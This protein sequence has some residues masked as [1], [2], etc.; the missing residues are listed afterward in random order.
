MRKMFVI[1]LTASLLILTFTQLAVAQGNWKENR[2]TNQTSE[3]LHVVFSTW[4]A[5]SGTVTETGYRTVGYYNIPP[6]DFEK[7]YGYQNNPIYLQIQTHTGDPIKPE[8]NTATVRSWL[9]NSDKRDGFAFNIVT[10][11]FG[12]ATP[13]PIS[14]TSV[15]KAQLSNRDGFIK[16]PNNSQIRV[17][18][19]WV[20]VAESPPNPTV[21]IP[22]T[23]LRSAIE[24]ELKRPAN[25]P[26]T[27]ADMETLT[28]VWS[29]YDPF[30][31]GTISDLTG[32]EFATNLKTLDLSGN[33]I[34]DISALANL[35][36]LTSLDLSGNNI[37]DISPL[38]NLVK[39]ETLYLGDNFFVIGGN[40]IS[41]IS[42]LAKLV[43]LTAL[44]LVEN[45]IS[46]ISALSGLTNLKYLYLSGNRISDFSP[47]EALIPNLEEYWNG[48]QEPEASNSL[49]EQVIETHRQTLIR[50]EVKAGLPILLDQLKTPEKQLLL[51]AATIN[52]VINT[53][54]SLDTLIDR[55]TLTNE[56]GRR[57]DQLLTLLQARDE[58]VIAF[59]RDP[60]VLEL[61]KEPAAVDEL[62]AW[63]ATRVTTQKPVVDST[64]GVNIPDPNLRAGIETALRKNT[65]DTITEAD[66]LTLTT[67]EIP[68]R[69]I[70]DLTGL[71]AAENLTKL[72]LYGN[73]IS[74]ISELS[75]MNLISSLHLSGNDIS[76]IS[77]LSGLTNLEYLRLGD[78]DISDIWPLS[79]LTNLTA[80][81][82]RD[83]NISDI[84]ALSQ[85]TNLTDLTLQN[86]NISDIPILSR[87]TNLTALPLS[88]NDISDISALSQLTNL[89][90]L[91]LDD[92][93]IS[94]ISAL[95]GLTNLQRLALDANNI[96]DISAL[97]QLTNL[98]HLFLRDNGISDIS[99]LSQLTNLTWLHL[100]GNQISDFSPIAGLTENLEKYSNENQK[101]VDPNAPVNIPDPNLRRVIADTLNTPQNTPIA[102]SDMAALTTLEAVE[103]S[104]T[105]LTGLA[106]AINLEKLNLSGN[107]ISDVSPIVN[108]GIFRL[109]LSGNNISDISPLENLDSLSVLDLSGNNISDV[110]PI[111]SW[112]L[113]NWRNLGWLDLSD[114]T[115]SDISPLENLDNLDAFLDVLDLSDNN[116]SNVSPLAKLGNLG[117]LRL[118]GNP[119]TDVTPLI[120]LR[121]SGIV[122][123]GV[124]FDD[125]VDGTSADTPV[126]IPDSVLRRTIRRTLNKP[127]NSPLTQADMENLR[128]LDLS[129]SVIGSKYAI[130]DL[131]GLEFATNLEKLNMGQRFVTDISPLANLQNL[132][133]LSLFSEGFSVSDISPLANLRNLEWLSIS[134]YTLSD[135]SPLEKL[136]N[137]RSLN[138]SNHFSKNSISD[139]SLLANLTKLEELDLQKNN[140]S[141]ISPLQNSRNLTTLNLSRNN[142]SD[143]SPLQNSRNLTT[144]NLS[145]NNISDISPLQNSRNLTTLNLSRNNISDISPLQNL[146]KLEQLYLSGNS[147]SDISPL[148][149]SRNLSSLNL[150]SNGLSDVSPLTNLRNLETLNLDGNPITNTVPLVGLIKNGTVISGVGVSYGDTVEI[151]D[152]NLRRAIA[153]SLELPKNT[154]IRQ[155]DMDRLTGLEAPKQ[156]ITNLTGLAFAIN[157][158]YLRLSNNSISDISP[159]ENLVK[160]GNLYLGS[161]SI[162]NISPLQNLTNLSILYLGSN[163]ISNISPLQNLT[164]LK[165]L[166]LAN[167]NI[168]DVSPLEKLI[169]LE[170]LWLDGNPITDTVPLVSLIKNGT[171]IDVRVA[172]GDM[173]EIPDPN[174]HRAIAKTLGL[175]ENTPITQGDM[176]TLT[177]LEVR[178]HSITDLTG[179]AFATNLQ[180][181]NLSNNSISDISP[182]QNLINLEQLLLSK[183]GIS[184]ISPLQ[185][186]INLNSLGLAN[187]SISDISPLQNL[188][189][190]NSLGL[191]N[192]NIPDISP[193]EKLIKLERL[194]FQENSISDISPLKNLIK[195]EWLGL[196]G[197]PITDTALLVSFIKHGT[198]LD[199]QVS[200]GDTIEILDPN[201]RRAIE[202]AL[203]LPENTTI[204]QSDMDRLTGLE[205]PKQS[206]TNLTGLEFAINLSG[207]DLQENSIS[208]ISP[209]EN[210]RL[211]RKLDLRNNNISDISP[212]QNFPSLQTLSLGGNS[213]SDISPLQ[214]LLN[215][216][217]LDLSHNSISDIS[218]LQ[219]LVELEWLLDLSHNNISDISPIPQARV[220]ALDLS[221]NNISDISPILK[222]PV[223]R[224]DASYDME[225]LDL[226]DNPI[227][228]LTHLIEFVKLVKSA[229]NR[230]RW[231]IRNLKNLDRKQFYE[232]LDYTY[233]IS[234]YTFG[235]P[236][237]FSSIS[238]FRDYGITFRGDNCA[239]DMPDVSEKLAPEIV[240]PEFEEFRIKSNAGGFGYA[241]PKAAVFT[242][243]YAPNDNMAW[244]IADTV[245]DDSEER[246]QGRVIITVELLKG[247]NGEAF[248]LRSNVVHATTAWEKA[249]NLKFDIIDEDDGKPKPSDIRVQVTK[250]GPSGSYGGAEYSCSSGINP[251]CRSGV[252]IGAPRVDSKATLERHWNANNA[253]MKLRADSGYRTALHEF[254]HALGLT[255][256]HLN[257][258]F[259]EY[260]KWKFTK[261]ELYSKIRKEFG[262]S[263]SEL[264]NERIDL[265]FLE[266]MD[267][268]ETL[269][270][271]DMESVMTYGLSGNLIELRDG[272][273]SHVK[274][275][276]KKYN[277]IPEN[278]QLSAGDQEFIRRCYGDPRQRAIISGSIEIEGEECDNICLSKD[279]IDTSY[280]IKPYAVFTTD[281]Y[282]AQRIKTFTW[283]GDCRVEVHIGTRK[284]TEDEVEIAVY[285]PFYQEDGK[286]KTTGDLDSIQCGTATLPYGRALEIDVRVVNEN[287]VVNLVAG[288]D[289]CNVPGL[290]LYQTTLQ[291]DFLAA[292]GDWAELTIKLQAKYLKPGASIP[293]APS[294]LI[295]S[296]PIVLKL[297]TS[298]APFSDINGD[299]QVDLKDLLLISKHIGQTAPAHLN[300]DV[301]ADG[302]VT[303]ADLVQVAQFLGQS[304]DGASA[305]TRF[306][307]PPEVTYA[308]VEGWI[309]Q[310][311]LADDGSSVF[312]QGIANLEYLLILMIPE[313]TALLTNYPN[314]FNPETWIPY[315]LATHA[316][317]TL[318]IYAA[319]GTVVR[320]LDLG[321]QEAGYYQ[322]KSRAAYWDGRN[323]VGERVASGLYFY[324]LTAGDFAATR[325]M[326]IMK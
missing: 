187:N 144:L 322:S 256:E 207:L 143:I 113:A 30:D 100:D 91:F 93:D 296:R 88:G 57:L 271:F 317:V 298:R 242:P 99:A 228:D 201:L 284:V 237:R 186:L 290:K 51:T 178:E 149:N 76:D 33:N 203:K 286:A 132:K 119:I 216:E 265:N 21:N 188:I 249:G 252:G 274:A 194:A 251:F 110:S 240:E 58:G 9:P 235:Y 32:L 24:R 318:T 139:I 147:I 11:V 102:E 137:L 295:D 281:V 299:G 154:T 183:N 304:Q 310:A 94:D 181:L 208:D 46:N 215:L 277:G 40:N 269:S 12:T 120:G 74:D 204:R 135:I 224:E 263:K 247:P 127:I 297:A 260:F 170:W 302:I 64:A 61:I 270:F 200:Y 50:P 56:E 283:G 244:R 321:H 92:N 90:Y 275:L 67:L 106:S 6:G 78:N 157:L 41:D 212:L 7:F 121:D 189:N 82:L 285:V 130:R 182:L 289:V 52:L 225:L 197:N 142:I 167:N 38:A 162:S 134:G 138:L 320:H 13:A 128:E 155:S 3:T 80:L 209:L 279:T 217:H 125:P 79:G 287:V 165:T 123:E 4:R 63:L 312:R 211:L 257:P 101:V 104:I 219:N 229:G 153:K 163:S 169:N 43:K 238:A 174:L 325:K 262:K 206:I 111:A 108:L 23:E 151:P 145:R 245:A 68:N 60:Q 168:S 177:K 146:I 236:Q 266:T 156:S 227:R 261:P 282:N 103:Q 69:G 42:P 311:R 264:S 133:W 171:R 293:S 253:T 75:E 306:V 158:E 45:N 191:A 315:H 250:G 115:I 305:P 131:R 98:E 185:N 20:A 221:H 307:A 180:T 309:R 124:S 34:S 83:N 172:Y 192:N 129:H 288:K 205:A 26:I 246:K 173:V 161:N 8:T 214:N 22:D 86:N 226:S 294:A 73:N 166:V 85:L 49:A 193:L 190:L 16:Y 2:V 176:E 313:E 37:S 199:V 202:K 218:P 1:T 222:L 150:S 160:L 77:D 10:P 44:S 326:L 148:Q 112:N 258:K 48:N 234:E 71:A 292:G 213:I 241:T 152:P 66:M 300:V 89:E 84:S 107:N 18:D 303:I 59:L 319:D 35:V 308:M 195:L 105:D 210:S 114:N 231:E 97:S 19:A 70:E 17:T 87:L 324:T 301:N 267:V 179:L 255:H 54:N 198:S 96:S 323:A 196:D 14:F 268:D 273:P 36:N 55:E 316:D 278:F 232:L 164:N 28:D 117:E 239:T 126:N 5:A 53:P 248:S 122:I 223:T 280:T 72:V 27:Q 230:A 118:G 184:D 243:E 272:A 159:L 136:L 140:I 29:G 259:D 62:T 95:S 65:G 15:P 141:D 233:P 31:G 116:I 39:L 254:G 81:F 291:G 25:T 314:P 109:Y 175:P 276:F 47:I 220:D